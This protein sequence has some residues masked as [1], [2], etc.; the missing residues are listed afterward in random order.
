MNKLLGVLLVICSMFM[1]EV[2]VN[3]GEDRKFEE[4]RLALIKSIQTILIDEEVCKSANDCSMKGVVFVSPGRLGINIKL[5]GV[6]SNAVFKRVSIECVDMYFELEQKMSVVL[7]AYKISKEKELEMPFW[8]S[9]PPF[10]V[11]ELKGNK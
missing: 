5:Y 4:Q 10:V 11:I 3:A 9:E 8:K 2:N 1:W 7:E 6:M